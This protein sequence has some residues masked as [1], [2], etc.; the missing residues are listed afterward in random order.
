MK[1]LFNKRRNRF[2]NA[3]K[4]LA[5]REGYDVMERVIASVVST[6]GEGLCIAIGPTMR[7]KVLWVAMCRGALLLGE[8]Q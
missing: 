8:L 7:R 5:G 2:D 6:I 4:S 3:A 1:P